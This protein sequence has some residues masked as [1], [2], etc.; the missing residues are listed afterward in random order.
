MKF[1]IFILCLNIFSSLSFAT[2]TEIKESDL[3]SLT[4]LSKNTIVRETERSLEN[5][6]FQDINSFVCGLQE[7]RLE[8]YQTNNDILNLALKNF[9]VVTEVFGPLLNCQGYEFYL[10]QTDWINIDSNWQT[11][12]STC[13]ND[14]DF[15]PILTSY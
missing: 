8:Y 12:G 5:H 6:L 14:N 1:I 4:G 15:G 11:Q 10:C 3:L 7:F 2:L 13:E 9:S